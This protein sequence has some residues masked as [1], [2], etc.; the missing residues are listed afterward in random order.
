MVELEA[1][2]AESQQIQMSNGLTPLL[3]ICALWVAAGEK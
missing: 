1:F 2:L 3:R